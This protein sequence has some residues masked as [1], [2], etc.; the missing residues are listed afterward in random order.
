MHKRHHF[1]N[2]IRDILTHLSGHDDIIVQVHG[3]Q[4]QTQRSRKVIS[5][6]APLIALNEI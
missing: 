4:S 6:T 2:L 1:A 3:Q 5:A